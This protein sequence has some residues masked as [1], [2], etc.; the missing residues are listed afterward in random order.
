MLLATTNSGIFKLLLVVHLVA[1]VV[2]FGPLIVGGFFAN[3]SKKR[4]GPEGL[5]VFDAY[6]HVAIRVAERVVYTV[7]VW[8]ILLVLLSNKAFEFSQTWIWLSLLLFILA[9]GLSHGVHIPNLRRMRALQGELVAMTPPAAGAA[10]SGP[11]PQVAQLEQ[12]ERR[13]AVVGTVLD[14]AFVVIIVL[15]VWKPGLG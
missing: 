5:A 3:E 2:G 12:C 11:P 4:P 1:A 10:P 14:L 13:A 9:I 7:P 6:E 15:M 8:G